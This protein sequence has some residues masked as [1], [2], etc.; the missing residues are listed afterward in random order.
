[1]TAIIYE[2][3]TGHTLK[4]AQMLSKKLHIPYYTIEE[5]KEKI[6]NEDKIIFLSWVY[7]S[8]IKKQ[9][10][11][12][13]YNI[14]C[15]GLVGAYPYSDKY[16]KTLKINNKI[17]KPIFYLRGGID[18]SKLNI[19]QKLLV[20]LAS[21]TLKNQSEETKKMFKQGY[22]FVKVENLEEIIKYLQIKHI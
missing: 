15:Y 7:A 22:N 18:Y 11:I 6:Q 19:F 16:L 1:M 20:K 12:S 5:A 21:K 2:T 4:Y 10:E 17:T 8:K 3:N 9:K 13:N 14:I